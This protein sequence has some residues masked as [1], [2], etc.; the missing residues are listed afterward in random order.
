M[1]YKKISGVYTIQNTVNSKIYVGC[2]I[3]ISKRINT[4]KI[5]LKRGVHDNIYLQRSWDKYG[6]NSFLFSILDV[7]EE[8]YILS[9]ENYWVNMLNSNN[10]KYGYNLKYAS[11]SRKSTRHSRETIEKIRKTKLK[12]SKK[13]ILTEE[14]KLLRKKI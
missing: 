10:K 3:N 12:Q 4:H 14:E 2:S 8:D 9:F 7:Y 13:I 11:P 5:K 1:A 6:E